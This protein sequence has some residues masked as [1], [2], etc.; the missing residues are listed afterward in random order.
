[1]DM[2]IHMVHRKNMDCKY[3]VLLQ[4]LWVSK[5]QHIITK[6]MEMEP[7]KPFSW[8]ESETRKSS[9][10]T[11]NG[12]FLNLLLIPKAAVPAGAWRWHKTC[13][14]ELQPAVCH[15]PV[16]AHAGDLWSYWDI[17]RSATSASQRCT[18]Q[19]GKSNYK[20]SLMSKRCHL[21]RADKDPEER[22]Q[23]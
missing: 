15:L 11:K 2:Q 21:V 1:M 22:G 4:T 14:P 9:V 10:F 20:L 17:T 6:D 18:G 8:T 3:D 23:L 5:K 19:Q 16:R 13:T 12:L 7:I